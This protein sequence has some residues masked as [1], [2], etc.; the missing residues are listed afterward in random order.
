[1]AAGGCDRWQQVATGGDRWRQGATGGD[2]RGERSGDMVHD[3][4][5]AHAEHAGIRRYGDMVLGAVM[6]LES[7]VLQFPNLF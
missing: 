4:P 3:P 6:A 5:P 1:M 7:D 2:R